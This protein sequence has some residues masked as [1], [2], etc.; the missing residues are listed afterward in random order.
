[1]E[2]FNI[3]LLKTLVVT[4]LVIGLVGTEYLRHLE[5]LQ[6]RKLTT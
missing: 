4:N 2:Q 5:S 6:V 3:W 1:M